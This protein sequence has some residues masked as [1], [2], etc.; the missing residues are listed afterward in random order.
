MSTAEQRAEMWN[1]TRHPEGGWYR[2]TY[3]ASR[4]VGDRAVGTAIYF[5]LSAAEVSR[6]HRID[7]DELWHHYEGQTLRIHVFG[8]EGYRSLLL[9]S[10]DAPDA[11][12]Q[13]IVEAGAWF[14]AEVVGETGYTLVGCTVAPAFEFEH[15]ELATRASLLRQWPDHT[16]LIER[17]T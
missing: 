14:G 17:L 13:H 8:T 16:T 1:L 11:R 2:E 15:F 10:L 9:G 4:H 7:A 12:P 6:I 3:R 5:L